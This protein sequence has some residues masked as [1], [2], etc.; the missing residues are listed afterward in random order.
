MR[1]GI[2]KSSPPLA[3]GIK[4]GLVNRSAGVDQP[5]PSP[6]ASGGGASMATARS[7]FP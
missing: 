5:P 3:G 1:E 2:M 6:P 4:G 7:L